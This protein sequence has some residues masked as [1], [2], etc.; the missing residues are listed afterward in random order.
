MDNCP[1]C[2]HEIDEKEYT[3]I[4][5]G[6]HYVFCCKECKSNFTA[7]P[8]RYINCCENLKED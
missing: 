6:I 1:V 7:E 5:D 4:L 3:S 2:G 8:Q